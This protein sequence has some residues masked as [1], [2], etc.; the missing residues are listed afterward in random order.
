MLSRQAQCTNKDQGKQKEV[1]G[2]SDGEGRTEKE[3]ET[4][5]QCYSAGS[6]DGRGPGARE[7]RQLPEAGKRQETDCLLEPP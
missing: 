3:T 4:D 7:Y 6:E 5:L 1:A 2:E